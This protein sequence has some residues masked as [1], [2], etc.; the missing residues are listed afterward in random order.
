MECKAWSTTFKFL[1]VPIITYI[2]NEHSIDRIQ[3]SAEKAISWYWSW[4]MIKII[5]YC[6]EMVTSGRNADEPQAA[7]TGLYSSSAYSSASP[8]KYSSS[9]GALATSGLEAHKS[10]LIIS[11]QELFGSGMQVKVQISMHCNEMPGKGTFSLWLHIYFMSNP[12]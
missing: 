6:W 7:Q 3:N 1:C 9:S 12:P 2:F 5:C 11:A 8:L 4:N 10:K